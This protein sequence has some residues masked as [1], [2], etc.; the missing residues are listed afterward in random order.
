MDIGKNKTTII[1][2]HRLSTISWVDKILVLDNG[3]V[4]ETGTHKE[5]VDNKNSLYNHFWQLQSDQ[6]SNEISL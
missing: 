2:A 3:K 6:V 5:L 4:V 1:I